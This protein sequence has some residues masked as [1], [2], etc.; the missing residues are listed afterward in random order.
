MVRE[1]L[2]AALLLLCAKMK[3]GGTAVLTSIV[4]SAN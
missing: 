2:R 4:G 1:E 3:P